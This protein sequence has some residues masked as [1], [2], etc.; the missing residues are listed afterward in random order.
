MSADLID[1]L[2]VVTEHNKA[3]WDGCN[4]GEFLIQYCNSCESFQWYPREICA[5]CGASDV[6][7]KMTSG[8]GLVYSYTIIRA[9]SQTYRNPNYYSNELPY[10]VG[11]IELPER[12]RLYARILGC[13]LEDIE[14]GMKVE[15]TFLKLKEGIQFPAFKPLASFS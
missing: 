4:R 10:A 9:P 8:K 15:V 6:G 11:L 7:W 1:S 2:P 3:F 13:R 5:R 12:V 14:I